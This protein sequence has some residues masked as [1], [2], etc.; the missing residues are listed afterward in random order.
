MPLA[1][2]SRGCSRFAFVHDAYET[3]EIV[4]HANHERHDGFIWLRWVDDGELWYMPMMVN[5]EH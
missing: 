2:S 5:S 3:C 1:P 4:R